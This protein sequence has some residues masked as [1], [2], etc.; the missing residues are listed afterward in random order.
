[1]AK[2]TQ[3]DAKEAAMAAVRKAVAERVSANAKT[4]AELGC[5]PRRYHARMAADA[6]LATTQFH[7]PRLTT[8]TGA[9]VVQLAR[10]YEVDAAHAKVVAAAVAEEMASA[11]AEMAKAVKEY[12]TAK[13]AEEA[14]RAE[15]EGAVA[16]AE[17]AATKAW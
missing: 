17:E 1:M 7:A 4:K 15:A 11:A 12:E 3:A 13:A 10:Q 6:R 14:K 2:A 5:T 16:A 9:A 8:G